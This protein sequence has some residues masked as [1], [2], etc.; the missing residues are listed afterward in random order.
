MIKLILSTLFAASTALAG[1]QVIIPKTDIIEGQPSLKN[2]M[3]NKGH[4]EKNVGS[5]VAYAD[6]AGTSPVDGAA[7]SPTVTCTRSTSGPI[8]GDGSLLLTKDAANRQG[9]GCAVSFAIDS[10][11]QAKVLSVKM[12]TKIGSGTFV[13]GT[14]TTDSDVTVWIYDVTNTT[15]I[16]PSS[17][18]ILTNS[19]TFDEEFHAEFQTASNSTS[20][21]LIFH[22]GSTSASAYTV[23]F[24]DIEISTNRLIYGV[25]TSGKISGGAITFGAVTTPPTKPTTR[26]RDEVYY[27]R[28]GKFAK[29]TY[30][31]D[32]TSNSGAAAGSGNYLLSLPNGLSA[33][34]SM[35]GTPNGGSTDTQANLQAAVAAVGYWRSTSVSA[36]ATIRNATMYSAT[37]V[38]FFLQQNG[39]TTNFFFG[40]AGLNLTETQTFT[41]DVWVPIAGWDSST[42]M[43]D[44]AST[45]IVSFHGVMLSNQAVTAN[46]TDI[47]V[48]SE[49]DT[50]G[51]WSGSVYTVPV[52]GDYQISI[53]CLNGGGAS[54]SVYKNASLFRR[55]TGCDN[56]AWKSGSLVMWGLKTG[57]TLSLRS[58]TTV[59]FT[60]A[61]NGQ[62]ATS[63][64]V[65]RLSG[66]NQISASETVAA[67]YYVTSAASTTSSNPFNFETKEFDTHN[68]VTTGAGV[69]KFTAPVGGIYQVTASV[70]C[71]AVTT[72]IRVYKNG[73]LYSDFANM[74]S[75]SAPASGSD[76]V[77]LVAGD[78]VAVYPTATCTP[79]LYAGTVSQGNH[80][81]IHRIGAR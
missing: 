43:S 8:R 16:Q 35:T 23:K 46:V 25:P 14:G 49:R 7:G 56:S 29:V 60:G 44:Q 65:F 75:T 42:L 71:G 61:A 74:I 31:W 63:I 67:R 11:D 80:I 28:Y 9:Q 2:Y 38:M 13:A 17:Y 69:W 32:V 19:S 68:A 22:V 51:A 15:I 50:H 1:T 21:K 5:F 55:I 77:N 58:D 79:T 52:A 66:P 41:I 72:T 57:D 73:S 62:V 24:D 36:N 27:V 54:V 3:G 64:S 12:R 10:A 18:K 59:T 76:L 53:A 4:F 26:V 34:T 6:A 40:S 48:T 45:R 70:Y 81:S 30:V 37:Q 33:D 20:Y 39:T 47:P 78:Y